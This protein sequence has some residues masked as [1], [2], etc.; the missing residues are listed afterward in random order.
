MRTITAQSL[1]S[2][3]NLS[4]SSKQF[5][6]ELLEGGVCFMPQRAMVPK[7]EVPCPQRR[8]ILPLGDL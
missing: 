1:G 3:L 4:C 7:L 6:G 5:P 8:V 2:G